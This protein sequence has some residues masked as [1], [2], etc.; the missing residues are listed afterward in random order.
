MKPEEGVEYEADPRHAEELT[1][2]ARERR[3]RRCFRA[4]LHTDVKGHASRTPRGWPCLVH[5]FN[6]QEA[7]FTQV[8]TDTCWAG[9]LRTRKSSS[10]RIVSENTFFSLNSPEATWRVSQKFCRFFI[11]RS[12]MKING[13]DVSSIRDGFYGLGEV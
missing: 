2:P 1:R 4:A 5:V 8:H 13:E 12:D 10:G 3:R 11:A 7:S 9:C 6:F